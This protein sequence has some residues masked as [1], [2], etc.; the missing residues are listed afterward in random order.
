[1]DIPFYCTRIK[2]KDYIINTL[3]ETKK[4][5]FK[6]CKGVGETLLRHNSS[7]IKYSSQR[8]KIWMLVNHN[9]M[10]HNKKVNFLQGL[11]SYTPLPSESASLL[12]QPGWNKRKVKLC[13]VDFLVGPAPFSVLSCPARCSCDRRC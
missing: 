10:K 3:G 11:G 13:I 1:M 4:R 5:N 12:L 9:R 7:Y 6:Q 2:F 8:S